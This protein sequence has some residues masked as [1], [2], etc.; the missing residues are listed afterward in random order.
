MKPEMSA[1]SE[2]AHG[3]LRAALLAGDSTGAIRAEIANLEAAEARSRELADEESAKVEQARSDRVE[4][5]ASIL[6]AESANRISAV[7]RALEPPPAPVTAGFGV[8][9]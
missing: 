3:R 1:R 6:T 5:A 4:V 9:R 2:D 8:P 7:L